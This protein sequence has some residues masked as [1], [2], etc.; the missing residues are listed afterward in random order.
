METR[1]E[2]ATNELRSPT[3]RGH[4]VAA[5]RAISLFPVD[6]SELCILNGRA[7]V[8]LNLPQVA[9]GLGDIVLQTG[10]TLRVPAGAHLVMEPWIGG[11]ALRFD[12]CVEPAAQAAFHREPQRFS[13]EVAQPSRE[14][15]QAL[16]QVAVAFTRLVRGLLGYSEYL[17][18]GRG[19]V[20]SR[21]ESNPP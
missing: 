18:A 12:W 9:G 8:T 20:L 5:H 17:V 2:S 4:L 3:R 14:L 11:E 19:R 1:S 21:F 6:D 16:G 15:A 7:W 10:E 13:R